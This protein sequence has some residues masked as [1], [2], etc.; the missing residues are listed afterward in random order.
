MKI[1]KG[2][3][4][5][6]K[7][8]KGECLLLKQKSSGSYSFISGGLV[9]GETYKD[10]VVKEAKE[11][12][13]LEIDPERL[14]DTDQKIRFTGSKKG[15]AEQK[16]FVYETED[17]IELKTDNFEISEYEWCIKEEAI[18]KLKN[19]LPLVRLLKDY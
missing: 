18:D 6:V 14:I 19:K 9:E 16:V 5:I 4:L 8:D 12:V 13:G 1:R 17:K 10:A 3:V 11:E 7:N 15:P 2:I